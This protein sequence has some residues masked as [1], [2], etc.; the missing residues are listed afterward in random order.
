MYYFLKLYPHL[1]TA[2][3]FFFPLLNSVNNS[4]FPTALCQRVSARVTSPSTS[5]PA[6]RAPRS[7]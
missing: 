4:D 3:D 5:S 1:L 6:K 2:D 7:T